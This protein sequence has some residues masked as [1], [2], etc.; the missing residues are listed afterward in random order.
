MNSID[1]TNVPSYYYY[2]DPNTTYL[3]QQPNPIDD[4]ITIYGLDDISKQVARTN[5]D[6]SKAVKL[7]KSYK[8]QIS[9]LSGK[10]NIIP[11]RENGKGG[12]MV[13]ILFQE[14]PDMMNQVRRTPG[15]SNE[16]WREQMINRDSNLFNGEN[17]GGIDWSLCS[18]VLNQFE[19]SYPTEF[20]NQNNFQIDDLA[21]DL[22]GSGKSNNSN[23]GS[24][25][26]KIKSNASSGIATPTSDLPEELKRRRLEL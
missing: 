2:I 6:G 3:P 12:E 4:L 1:E 8:N 15:M 5:I 16:Q 26:R 11:T 24:R 21:F 25:K 22:D 7:R 23:S 14:N 18:N 19:R 9:D 10:F 17:G 13:H 20:Q